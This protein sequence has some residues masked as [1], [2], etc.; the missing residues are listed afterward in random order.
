MGRLILRLLIISVALW[1]V[2][3]ILRPHVTVT[4]WGS[5]DDTVAYLV[6]L[7]LV[8]LVFGVV[9]AVIGGFVRVVAFPVYLLTLGLVSFIVN[10]LLLLLV[11]WLSTLVGFGL[12]IESFWWGVLGAFLLGVISWFIGVV[13][14]PFTRSDPR[15]R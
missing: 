14:R 8:A 9:N 7:V 15:R 4:S 1:L 10:G 12:A 3:L 5:P 11:A 6:T 2:T 13:L